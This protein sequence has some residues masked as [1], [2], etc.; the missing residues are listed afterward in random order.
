M[1]HLSGTLSDILGCPLVM[2]HIIGTSENVKCRSG[3]T[4]AEL[5]IC[6]ADELHNQYQRKRAGRRTYKVEFCVQMSIYGAE[7]NTVSL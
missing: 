4:S 6:M 3:G 1:I 2:K 5:K 7:E